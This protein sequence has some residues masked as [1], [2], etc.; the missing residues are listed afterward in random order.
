MISLLERRDNDWAKHFILDQL[1]VMSP[2]SPGLLGGHAFV[3]HSVTGNV[4]AA[5]D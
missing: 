4:P 3:C 5:R 2:T 1:D